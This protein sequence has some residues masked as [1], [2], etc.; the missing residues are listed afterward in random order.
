[1]MSQPHDG[2][3]RPVVQ[4]LPVRGVTWLNMSDVLSDVLPPVRPV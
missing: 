3:D 1:M 2:G 4:P